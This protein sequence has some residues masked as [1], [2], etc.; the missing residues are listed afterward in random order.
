MAIASYIGRKPQAVL[1]TRVASHLSNSFH[2]LLY[3]LLWLMPCFAGEGYL[4]NPL[5]QNT[6]AVGGSKQG[7]A[8]FFSR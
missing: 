3:Q 6:S 7:P 2:W 4:D 1:Q 5:Q 8:G